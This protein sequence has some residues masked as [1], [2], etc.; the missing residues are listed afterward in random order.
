MLA[1]R[2][3]SSRVSIG[4]TTA[5]PRL[6]E[7]NLIAHAWLEFGGQMLLGGPDVGRYTPLFTWGS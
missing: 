7:G 6:T 1:R 5:G 2:G 4:V 3:F